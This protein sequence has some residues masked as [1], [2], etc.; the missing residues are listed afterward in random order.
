MQNLSVP[1]NHQLL[2]LPRY[3]IS[4]GTQDGLRKIHSDEKQYEWRNESPL[5]TVGI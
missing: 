4:E 2:G 3:R 1:A 5:R